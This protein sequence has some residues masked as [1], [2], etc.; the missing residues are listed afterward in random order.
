MHLAYV[1]D[2]KGTYVVVKILLECGLIWW[3]RMFG[4]T[5]RFKHAGVI[6]CCLDGLLLIHA[7]FFQS[8]S[9]YNYDKWQ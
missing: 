8:G 3:Y 4:R 7:E 2:A 9:S 5:Q 1:K 6:A